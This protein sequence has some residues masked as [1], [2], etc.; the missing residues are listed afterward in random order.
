VR[1]RAV[2]LT[3]GHEAGW[4]RRFPGARSLLRR[5][6]DGRST[7]SPTL[8]EYFR[9]R[10]ARVLVAAGH[11]AKWSGWRPGVDVTFLSVPARGGDAVRER[12][13]LT[14]RPGWW[15][16]ACPGWCR[17]KGPGT[18]LITA[19]P[20]DKGPGQRCG[21]A[22][23]VGDGSPTRPGLKA[24]GAAPRRGR[25]LSSSPA[26]FPV[27]RTPRPTNDAAD[28]FRHAL[29]DAPGRPGRGGSRHRLP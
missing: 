11:S 3:H 9:A 15:P 7:W 19:W 8:G 1:A 28:V 17:A 22:L 13:G 21:P 6:G 20:A 16:A 18:P 26:Q 24:A 10:L 5:I 4:G 14:G 29:P 2:A 23:L 27:A 12:L 25:R